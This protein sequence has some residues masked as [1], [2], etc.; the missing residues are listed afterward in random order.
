MRS[1]RI[2]IFLTV[3]VLIAIGLVMIYSASSITMWQE[4]GRGAGL[5]V[6][7]LFYL[8]VGCVV[9]FL[10]MII[11]YQKLKDYAKPILIVS[12]F[13]LALVLV[14]G[15]SREVGGARRWFHFGIFNFQPSEFVKISLIIYLADFISR[16]KQV[17]K[18]FWR[19]FVPPMFVLAVVVLAVLLQPDL[20][21]AIS[22]VVLAFVMLFASGARMQ[23]LALS[24]VAAMPFLYFLVFSVPYRRARVLAFLNPWL[25]PKGAGFQ[26]IQSQIALGSGGLFGT[27][28][29]QGK[30]KLFY[31][32]A[33]HTDFIFSIIAEETGLI[34]SVVVVLLFIF[35]IWKMAQV[36]YSI[37]E[38]F[39]KL[40]CIG[41]LTLVSF[42]AIV[43]IGVSIGA[44]PTKGLPLPFI[45]YGGSS[46]IFHMAAIGLFLNV[47]KTEEG[48]II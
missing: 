39:G 44:F 10:C 42:S 18:E 11:D 9:M 46:L 19:G 15:I 5:L 36:I 14:P 33:A 34:G 8:V 6:K 41:V 12:I 35:L 45:S 4:T 31:L 37:S 1:L 25:D 47:S 38:P 20:G 17:V 16:R 2:S 43:N 21:T 3:L 13:S 29:G 7:Q 40:I 23:H 30:Q 24:V 27:G 32:P 48:A 22:F 26:I 28:L